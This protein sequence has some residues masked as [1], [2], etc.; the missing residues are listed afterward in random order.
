[1]MDGDI[2]RWKYK[3]EKVG[4]RSVYGRYHCKSQIAIA[5]NGW[6]IDTFWRGSGDATARTYA[7][8]QRDWDLTFL[9]NMSALRCV[10]E[11]MADYYADADI[12][13]LNHSNSSRGNFYVRKDAKRCKE[14]MLA[15]LVAKIAEKEREAS[16]AQ[17]QLIE[18]REK[19]AAIESGAD[20]DEIYL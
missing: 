5:K 13:D 17:R 1:M 7:E 18:T 4:D 15:A 8:A 10:P 12:V 19:H 20:V 11:Y 16:W 6:L 3:D 2:F 14:K 9:A